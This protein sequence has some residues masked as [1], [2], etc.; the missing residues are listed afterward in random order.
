MGE[1]QEVDVGRDETPSTEQK[2]P[3]RLTR[4]AWWAF[5]GLPVSFV[6]AALLGGW[7]ISLQGYDPDAE[8]SL[9]LR[10]VLVAGVP[11][12]LVLL[13][14]LLAAALLG[15]SAMRHGEAQGRNPMIVGAA[16][17]G[18]VLFQSILTIVA[19]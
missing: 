19:R 6:A 11:A 8:E 5:A 2:A 10:V 18:F 17:A 15:R 9:P 14:P 16:L 3:S 1:L 13:I 7:L 12:T 4:R